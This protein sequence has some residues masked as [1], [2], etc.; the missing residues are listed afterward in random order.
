MNTTT[1]THPLPSLGL[2]PVCGGEIRIRRNGLLYKHDRPLDS[3]LPLVYDSD[4]F[5]IPTCP[6]SAHQAARQMTPTFAQWL[7]AQRN[8]DKP[9]DRVAALADWKFRGCTRSPNR[10]PADVEWAT[11]EDLHQHEHD[12]Q[13]RRTGSDV[14]QPYNGRRCDWVCRDIADA[15]AEYQRLVAEAA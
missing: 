6:G 7:W 2:C 11:A 12:R 1:A 10:T 9:T 13:F 8:G 15:Q 14:R 3:D 5:W 4:G